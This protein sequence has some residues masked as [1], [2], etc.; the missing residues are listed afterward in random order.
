MIS[1]GDKW[2]LGIQG[3]ML[4]TEFGHWI[5]HHRFQFDEKSNITQIVSRVALARE[6]EL[7]GVPSDK[8]KKIGSF[9]VNR[10]NLL[11][12]LAARFAQFGN[13]LTCSL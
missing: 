3:D 2:P 12:V 9:H 7:L 4:S 1:K 6:I 13:D 10:S 8:S 11:K 5:G